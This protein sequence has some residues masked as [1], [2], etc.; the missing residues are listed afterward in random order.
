MKLPLLKATQ[1]VYTIFFRLLGQAQFLMLFSFL[2]MMMVGDLNSCFAETTSRPNI[3]LIMTDD[4]GYGDVGIHGNKKIETPVLD[5][6]A[7]ESTRFDRFMVSPLCSMTRAS[8]LTGRYH[9]RTGCAS[10]TRGVETVRPDEVLIS[11]I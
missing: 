11:E 2:F 10:V 9:L 7:R 6:L 3:L 1:F 4:Q 5:K 8:L